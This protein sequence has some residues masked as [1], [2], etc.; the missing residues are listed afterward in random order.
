MIF[1]IKKVKFSKNFSNLAAVSPLSA[2]MQYKLF[3]F[4]LPGKLKYQKN[5]YDNNNHLTPS[6]PI[7]YNVFEAVQVGPVSGK[8]VVL[9]VCPASRGQR[10]NEDRLQGDQ[11]LAEGRLL[12]HTFELLEVNA[13]AEGG[14][15]TI[16][17]EDTFKY[18]SSPIHCCKKPFNLRGSINFFI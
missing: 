2:C 17:L 4:L 8:S 18:I 15:V 6:L 1:V 3:S 14:A 12:H 10:R 9:C 11:D 7:S 16:H 13:H 5:T